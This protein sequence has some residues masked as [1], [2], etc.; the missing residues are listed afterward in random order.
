MLYM[1]SDIPDKS[2]VFQ[3]LYACGT[4]EAEDKTAA[5]KPTDS[6]NDILIR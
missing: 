2:L 5:K 4:K 3:D 6:D 1:G